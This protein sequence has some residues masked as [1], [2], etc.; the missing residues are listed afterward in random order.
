MREDYRPSR[1]RIFLSRNWSSCAA[2]QFHSDESL[3]AVDQRAP[4]NS[5]NWQWTVEGDCKEPLPA[6]G[7][8]SNERRYREKDLARTEEK[9]R[10]ERGNGRGEQWR[11]NRGREK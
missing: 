11:G 7:N 2:E 1:R 4:N 3:E 9:K 5:K 10:S 8:R 6:P